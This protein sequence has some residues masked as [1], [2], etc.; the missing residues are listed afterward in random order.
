MNVSYAKT[1]PLVLI[2]L[3]VFFDYQYDGRY[4]DYV[5]IVDGALSILVKLNL[6]KFRKWRKKDGCFWNKTP[7]K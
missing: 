6:I 2:W 1:R 3:L 5:E 4:D 7:C